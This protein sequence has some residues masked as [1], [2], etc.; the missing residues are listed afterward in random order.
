MREK[1]II[2]ATPHV[3][4]APYRVGSHHYAGCFSENGWRVAYISAPITPFHIA[5]YLLSPARAKVCLPPRLGLWAKGGMQVDN[6]WAYVPFGLVPIANMPFFNSDWAI[7]NAHEY[8]I[9]AV[10]KKLYE[11]SFEEVDLIWLDSPL[12]WYLL[13]M[14]PHKKSILRVA[15]DLTGFPE[16]GKNIIDTEKELM[17]R[18]DLVVV[19]SRSLQNRVKDAGAKKI[20]YLP[21]GVD[22]DHFANDISPEPEDLK[23]IPKPRL[24][25]V[26][27]IE[28]WFDESLIFFAALQRKDISFVIIGRYRRGMFPDLE[29]MKNI[30]FLGKRDYATIPSYMKNSQAGMIPFKRLRFIDSVNPIKLYEY[31]ACGLPVISTR[32]KT[33]EEMESPAYLA[34]TKEEFLEYIHKA[35]ESRDSIRDECTDFGNRNSWA[36]RFELL[37]EYL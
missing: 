21:N 28:R 24:I 33:I 34:E 27:S 19:S 12:F 25:Y 3:W 20:L 23:K 14:M 26:G 37:S 9:P 5:Y 36:R 8:F 11:K 4:N 6:I 7:K 29:K 10:K 22:L 31:M 15:D 13:E 16:L 17:G 2:I 30:H 32:W 18:V 35:L 1:K